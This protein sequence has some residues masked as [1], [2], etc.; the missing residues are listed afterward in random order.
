MEQCENC[1]DSQ[2]LD[3]DITLIKFWQYLKYSVKQIFHLLDVK[4][5]GIVGRLDFVKAVRNEAAKQN[6]NLL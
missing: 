4:E 6:S 5:E 2:N 3:F 1:Q